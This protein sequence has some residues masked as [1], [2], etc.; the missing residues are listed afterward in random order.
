MVHHLAPAGVAGFVLANGSM[1]SSQSDRIGPRPQRCRGVPGDRRARGWV[2]A[3][4]ASARRVAGRRPSM[5][6]GLDF[7]I[8]TATTGTPS[9]RSW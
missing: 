6:V 2:R 8:M 5:C 3:I 4:A 7:G 1:S 9:T